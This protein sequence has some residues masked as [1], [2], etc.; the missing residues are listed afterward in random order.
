MIETPLSLA[1][2][3]AQDTA[4]RHHPDHADP[5]IQAERLHLLRRALVPLLQA[6]GWLWSREERP[7]EDF[8]LFTETDLLQ[9][10][11]S[12]ARDEAVLNAAADLHRPLELEELDAEE[13]WI[14]RM[15][16]HDSLDGFQEDLRNFTRTHVGTSLPRARQPRRPEHRLLPSL[17]VRAVV[18]MHLRSL[19]PEIALLAEVQLG[20]PGA[21]ER[22]AAQNRRGRAL[23][24]LGNEQVLAAFHPN[25]EE[26]PPDFSEE[27]IEARAAALE[28]LRSIPGQRPS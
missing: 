27:V 9:V 6:K 22:F 15:W 25:P 3:I 12:L 1:Q 7:W 4:L 10:L 19:Q 28:L 11:P 21:Q 14:Q 8:V 5:A 24:D 23:R 16:H 18:E 2:A 17:R 13:D 26:P 20:R